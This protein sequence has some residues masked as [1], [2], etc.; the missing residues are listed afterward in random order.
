MT[1]K[2]QT[3]IW[4]RMKR[5]LFVRKRSFRNL[6]GLINLVQAPIF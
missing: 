2:G 3:E 1:K 4:K 6:A 5:I